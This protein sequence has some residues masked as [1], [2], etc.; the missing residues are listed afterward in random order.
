MV[1]A[2]ACGGLTGGRRPAPRTP[3]RTE[4]RPDY[5]GWSRQRAGLGQGVVNPA[6]QWGSGLVK[7]VNPPTQPLRVRRSRGIDGVPALTTLTT[8]IGL[9]PSRVEQASRSRVPAQCPSRACAGAPGLAAGCRGLL[10]AL[11]SSTRTGHA[12]RCRAPRPGRWAGPGEPRTRVRA[13]QPAG[14]WPARR[15]DHQRP[16]ATARATC[17]RGATAPVGRRRPR[18]VVTAGRAV[19]FVDRCNPRLRLQQHLFPLNSETA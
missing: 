17:P 9:E 4:L 6:S 10:L 14:R 12:V 18:A 7:A 16:A 19:F 1:K 5:W 15:G 2:T 11:R 3:R 13:L 8:R